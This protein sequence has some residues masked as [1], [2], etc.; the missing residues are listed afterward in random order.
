MLLSGC[1][2]ANRKLQA[3]SHHLPGCLGLTPPHSPSYHT[4]AR[5]KQTQIPAPWLDPLT[6]QVPAGSRGHGGSPRAAGRGTAGL[7]SQQ[8]IS[9]SF[10]MGVSVKLQK[11]MVTSDIPERRRRVLGSVSRVPFTHT[12]CHP[13]TFPEAMAGGPRLACR[14]QHQACQ[15]TTAE[16]L[17]PRSLQ[18]DHPLAAL[19]AATLP[20]H[21]A[22][23]DPTIAR[24][25]SEGGCVEDPKAHRE[26]P[27]PHPTSPAWGRARKGLC[28]QHSRSHPKFPLE[29]V[30]CA[31]HSQQKKWGT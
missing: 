11:K 29:R 10:H 6:G 2:H 3:P 31:V 25:S 20:A 9:P 13:Q 1:Q 16:N 26:D 12:P 30:N 28:P 7:P 4:H 8:H 23:T 19:T 18:G 17:V 14:L 15:R 27:F 22:A 24:T 21:A 5:R